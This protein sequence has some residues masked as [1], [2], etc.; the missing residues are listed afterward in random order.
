MVE[1]HRTCQRLRFGNASCDVTAMVLSN[2]IL[3][4]PKAHLMTR[5]H[6]RCLSVRW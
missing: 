2:R 3:L 5:C 4:P 1:H 6:P